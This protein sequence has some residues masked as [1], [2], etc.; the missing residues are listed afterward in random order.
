MKIKTKL[1]LPIISIF[2]IGM[3]IYLPITFNILTK[4]LTTAT[5]ITFFQK[6]DTITKQF[7]MFV[8]EEKNDYENSEEAFKQKMRESFY[9]EENKSDNLTGVYK[10]IFGKAYP[11]IIDSETTMIY[12]I[13][14]ELEGEITNIV[15]KK[16]KELLMPKIVEKKNGILEYYYTRPGE[17]KI[18][19]KVALIRYYE[20]LDY[21]I[22]YS[23][24]KDDIHKL[25]LKSWLSII[26]PAGVMALVIILITFI[27]INIFVSKV[28]KT[29]ILL[30]D[31]SEGEGDLTKKLKIEGNDEVDDLS[32]NFNVFTDKL[33]TLINNVKKES[34]SI[35]DIN[36][37]VSAATE[38]TSAAIEEISSNLNSIDSQINT[39]DE[40]IN[41]IVDSITKINNNIEQVDEEIVDQASMVEESTAA[42]T[43]MIASLNSVDKITKAKKDSTEELLSVSNEGKE[44]I[45]QTAQTFN[46]VLGFVEKIKEMADVINN[47]AAQ[48]NLLAMNAAIE[49]AH[50]GDAGRGF[51]VVAE[52]IRKLADS[53]DSSSKSIF[54][55]IKKITSSV[56][57]T[58]DNVKTTASAFEKITEKVDD[59]INAF[60]QIEESISELSIGGK[61]VLDSSEQLNNVAVNIKNSSSSIREDIKSL[62]NESD[63]VKLISKSVTGGITE[64]KSGASEI[65]ESMLDVKKKI[66]KLSESV[67]LLQSN[68]GKFKT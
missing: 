14:K 27:S 19:K 32:N 45:E 47:I 22:V 17:T 11:Y 54:E 28:S 63:N 2:L 10:D 9:S 29:K 23:Y 36:V 16:T 50:A 15:D 53:S 5:E 42:I 49:A 24:Y 30:K 48:T 13:K 68:I 55:V 7:D 43:E 61:Q 39:L 20:P 8:E 21:Y 46:E 34:N 31:I 3:A 40:N 18:V 41:N 67:S 60:I 65:V 62:N 38:E 33:K 6:I 26:M 59:T 12:Y 64:S 1:L 52:E 25:I 35:E 66:L 58:N 57:D 56:N 4:Q 37:S 44:N 51:A